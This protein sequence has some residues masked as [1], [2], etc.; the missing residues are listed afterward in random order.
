MNGLF[1]LGI[2][3]Q[4]RGEISGHFIP[5]RKACLVCFTKQ[6]LLLLL[7]CIKTDKPIHLDSKPS[8]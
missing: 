5:Y 7:E 8:F 4:I 3:G 1:M 6:G 2:C